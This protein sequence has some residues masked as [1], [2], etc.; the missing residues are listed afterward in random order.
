MAKYINK[1]IPETKPYLLFDELKLQFDLSEARQRYIFAKS[2]EHHK[3]QHDNSMKEI[4]SRDKTVA[5]DPAEGLDP[6]TT[7]DSE[8][9]TERPSLLRHLQFLRKTLADRDE[10]FKTAY[11]NLKQQVKHACQSTDA[12]MLVALKQSMKA[13]SKQ[14]REVVDQY[15]R[16]FLN[17]AV[18]DGDHFLVKL[19]L[20]VGFN[21]NVEEG[22]GATPLVL[23]AVGENLDIC[24]LLVENLAEIDGPTFL[25][26]HHQNNW[27]NI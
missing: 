20:A 3:K 7:Y 11:L 18:E 5:S 24:K 8:E 15:K 13:K 12:G 19:L 1:E 9:A 27:P 25:E 14:T 2:M 22:C 26:S 17:E 10:K 21:P 23:A 6:D 16:T 4:I